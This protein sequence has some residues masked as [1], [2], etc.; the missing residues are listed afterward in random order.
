LR[1]R[2]LPILAVALVVA[3]T[4]AACGG[5]GDSEDATPSTTVAP[6][7]TTVP[8]PTT[9]T[10]VEATTTTPAP[11]PTFPLTGLPIDDPARAARPVLA[12]KIDN[13]ARAR[14]QVGL[15]QADI[16]FEE[17]VER[18]SRYVAVF[19]SRD[20]D[21]V[22]PV[23][24]A[25]TSDLN[26]L[27]NLGSMPL[28][29]NSGG[30]RGTMGLVHRAALVD[31]GHESASSGF[32]YR[33]RS[34][35]APHNLFV[36]TSDLYTAAVPESK[37]PEAF[38]DYRQ[39]GEGPPPTAEAIT[40]VALDFDSNRS[41]FRWN[42][43]TSSWDRELDG[44]P[45]VDDKDV[46]VSPTNVITLFV[47]Y[48]RSPADPGSPEA[49]TV[50]EGE[51]W[52]FVGGQLVRGAWNRPSPAD[53]YQLLDTAGQPIKLLPGTTWIALPRDGRAELLPPGQA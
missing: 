20:S 5:G 27:A 34:R 30:N 49:R 9:T 23:R 40:G 11:V 32:F 22:G 39:P 8:A 31:V 24:S 19:Q 4:A 43:T 13:N 18:A 50:G 35:R 46:L 38:F 26:I 15:N 51:A 14:P 28:F 25:R 47:D 17:L 41:A 42:P 44:T 6:T 12:V 29:A 7:T 33:E 52:V 1:T 3:A 16:V 48:G 21:P 2:R 45:H 53:R 37:P 36:K 10:T